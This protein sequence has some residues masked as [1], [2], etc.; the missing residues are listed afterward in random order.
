MQLIVLNDRKYRQLREILAGVG[1]ALIVPQSFVEKMDRSERGRFT[2][3]VD[4]TIDDDPYVTLSF[5]ASP[6]DWPLDN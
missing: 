4:E 6:E 1:S 5:C 2:A 3:L